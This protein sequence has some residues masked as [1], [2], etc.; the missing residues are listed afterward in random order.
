MIKNNYFGNYAYWCSKFTL[1]FVL[2][3]KGIIL[4]SSFVE[5]YEGV[6]AYLHSTSTCVI[7]VGG[8]LSRSPVCVTTG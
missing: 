1:N 7:G 8:W 6:K 2:T 3:I 5:V 4:F